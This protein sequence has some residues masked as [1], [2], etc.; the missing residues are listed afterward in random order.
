MRD[1][2]W[3]F[4]FGLGKQLDDIH[5][6]KAYI[7]YDG[8]DEFCLTGT[9]VYE[10]DTPVIKRT[11]GRAI[12]WLAKEIGMPKEFNELFRVIELMRKGESFYRVFY[13]PKK[14]GGQRKFCAPDDSLKKIQGN[15]NK[16]FLSALPVNENAFGFSRGNIINAIKPH[17]KSKVILCVDCMDA[18][19]TIKDNHLMGLFTG[20]VIAFD[21][22]DSYEGRDGIY[23]MRTQP[24][25]RYGNYL[26]WYAAKIMTELTSFEGE[27]PQ[28]APTSP[29]LFDLSCRE[30]D[31]RL[32]KLA[33]NVGGVY[34]RYADNIFFSISK[35]KF[36]RPLRQAIVKT[37]EG[38]RFKG[39]N[40]Q[41]KYPHLVGFGWHKL[42]I[43]QANGTCQKM[44]GLNVIDG[45][46]HNT[47]S[48]KDVCACPFTM[49]IG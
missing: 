43:R 26:S 40:T 19:P 35:E 2:D 21:S 10:R 17:L 6:D 30:M 46:I 28:G 34:T 24:I 1:S 29:R 15:I 23:R 8:D 42:T 27:L 25:I 18:F 13:S 31:D 45:K 39:Y 38:R 48:F 44:L 47:R 33:E 36:P 49:L 32:A 11:E 20:N 16:H 9:L 3:E 22:F 37:I 12:F 41:E 7:I 14:D 4:L 5:Y